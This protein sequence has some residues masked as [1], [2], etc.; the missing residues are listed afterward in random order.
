VVA[1]LSRNLED[2]QLVERRLEDLPWPN[3]RLVQG[4]AAGVDMP[5]KV[6]SA[7][8]GLLYGRSSAIYFDLDAMRWRFEECLT[9]GCSR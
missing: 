3:L 2:L 4:V 5:G 9:A 7:A 1:R 6:S 8:A